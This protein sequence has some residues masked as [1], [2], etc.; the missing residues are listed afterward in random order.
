MIFLNQFEAQYTAPSPQTHTYVSH[1][2]IKKCV[3]N[4]TINTILIHTKEWEGAYNVLG[5]LDQT[6]EM[7]LSLWKKEYVQFLNFVTF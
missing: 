6:R 5:I 3:V 1:K 2:H 7:L 4:V